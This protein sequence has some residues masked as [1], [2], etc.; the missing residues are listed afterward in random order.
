MN[1]SLSSRRVLAPLVFSLGL[2]GCGSG[3]IEPGMA[4]DPNQ[5]QMKLDPKMVDVTG[6]MGIGAAKKAAEGAAKAAK[7]Q[8][9]PAPAENK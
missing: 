4:N 8:P 3:G 1:R 7:E 6:K 5:P 2:V 9:A